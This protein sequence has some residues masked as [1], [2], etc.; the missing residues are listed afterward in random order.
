MLCLCHGA[1]LQ[2]C[3]LQPVTLDAAASVQVLAC[4]VHLVLAV[5]SV[6]SVSPAVKA[7]LTSLAK[8]FLVTC[9]HGTA[10]DTALLVSRV[11]SRSVP[12]ALAAIQ[13]HFPC[14]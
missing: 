3:L 6:N 9:V 12:A 13:L 1:G 5:G 8:V 10:A 2:A 4:G 14:T 11:T 7:L